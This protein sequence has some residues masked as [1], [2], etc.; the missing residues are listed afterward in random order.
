MS[1]HRYSMR[2]LGADYARAGAGMAMTLGPLLFV[3]PGPAMIAVLGGLGAIF[4]IFAVRTW[5]RQMTR[6]EVSEEGITTE[7]SARL[8]PHTVISWRDL[9]GLQLKY[10]STRRDRREGWLQM[11]LKT[12]GRSLRVDSNLD[13]FPVVARH[14]AEAARSNGLRLT[15]ATIDNLGALGIVIAGDPVAAMAAPPDRQ[16]HGAP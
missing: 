11:K 6:V 12:A 1:V 9:S 2:A 4:L 10:Y 7:S 13:D 16:L 15:P 8:A 5:L 3:G 14:A